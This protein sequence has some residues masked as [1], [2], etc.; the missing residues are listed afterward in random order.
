MTRQ[1]RD[2]LFNQQQQE[3]EG[4]NR[5]QKVVKAKDKLGVAW[6]R[7]TEHVLSAKDNQQIGNTSNGN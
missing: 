5:Q 2:Q 6:A 3:S 7:F 4:Y 1:L